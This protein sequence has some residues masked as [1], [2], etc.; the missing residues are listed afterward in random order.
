MSERS[1]ILH[2][3]VQDYPAEPTQMWPTLPAAL[4]SAQSDAI[5]AGTGIPVAFREDGRWIVDDEA[6][7][8]VA[9]QCW[10]SGL[11]SPDAALIKLLRAEN[12]TNT[13]SLTDICD[14]AAGFELTAPC[15]ADRMSR[16]RI[17][18]GGAAGW[19]GEVGSDRNIRALG[20]MFETMT[21]A[22]DAV[23]SDIRQRRDNL[24]NILM[25]AGPLAARLATTRE[26][27]EQPSIEVY[28]TE[29]Q[30]NAWLVH[31]PA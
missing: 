23:I 15:D 27:W 12:S 8:Q 20:D 4:D 6:L 28:I 5:F 9:G 22:V 17:W 13:V 10:L 18:P 30:Q 25:A 7:H 19:V 16:G 2:L 21:A 26:R 24:V 1:D 31:A 3:P 14:A 11:P 29:T